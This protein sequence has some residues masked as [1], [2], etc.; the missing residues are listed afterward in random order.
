LH[1]TESFDA[2]A[3]VAPD[4]DYYTVHPYIKEQFANF[5]WENL[6]TP[7][8]KHA[9]SFKLTL[10][11]D[12]SSRTADKQKFVLAHETI[13]LLNLHSITDI[14]FG[15]Y[16][17]AIK[18]VK[19]IFTPGSKRGESGST[20]VFLNNVQI[21]NNDNL[22]QDHK[23][24]IAKIQEIQADILPLKFKDYA[25]GSLEYGGIGHELYLEPKV[26]RQSAKRAVELHEAWDE[27]LKQEST[28][29]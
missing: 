26:R 29:R 27:M 13:H 5:N 23:K 21:S 25:Q 17:E 1:G 16:L 24:I 20:A 2:M 12:F 19:R 3:G 8:N 9:M 10:S 14:I 7:N 28:I 15:T 18:G 6:L 22:I 4:Y 11:P